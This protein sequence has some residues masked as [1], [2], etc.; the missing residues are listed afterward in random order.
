MKKTKLM[1]AIAAATMAAASMAAIP[2]FSASAT[3]R[4]VYMLGDVNNDYVVDTND[5]FYIL[6]AM[7]N[8]GLAEGSRVNVTYVQDHLSDWFPNA[9]CAKAA[10]AD[11]DGYITFDDAQDVLTY[12]AS[13][14]AGHDG[15][16]N[17]GNLYFYI[18]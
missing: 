7:G 2:S 9:A 16:K 10:D 8:H 4:I 12:Y 15:Y 5:A 17:I 1:A 11:E 3:T 18:P 13:V 14:S 6:N